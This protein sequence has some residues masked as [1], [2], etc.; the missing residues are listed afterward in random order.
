MSYQRIGEISYLSE[1]DDLK[2]NI[3]YS[4]VV[5]SFKNKVRKHQNNNK[6]NK[7]S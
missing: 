3:I 4:E 2:T 7:K 6:E 5:D 1:T